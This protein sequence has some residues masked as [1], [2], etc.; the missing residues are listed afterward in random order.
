MIV[1]WSGGPGRLS[2][3]AIPSRYCSWPAGV[4]RNSIRAGMA[5]GLVKACGQPAG[6]NIRLPGPPRTTLAPLADSQAVQSSDAL[7]RGSN[8]SKSS[9]P[10]R[11]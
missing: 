6:T 3:S 5:P 7:V 11:M 10:S 9:S 8:A 2:S 1:A 4:T